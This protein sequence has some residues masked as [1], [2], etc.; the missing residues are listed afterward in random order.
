VTSLISALVAVA[1]LRGTIDVSVRTEVRARDASDGAVVG[2]LET[3]LNVLAAAKSRQWEL[4]IGYA[5]RV[6]LRG[7]IGPSPD[8]LHGVVLG[9]GYRGRRESLS[10]YGEWSV[11][12]QTWTP[13][14]PE[15][16]AGSGAAPVV[17]TLPAPL[18]IDY[19]ASRTGLLAKL[20]PARRWA[21][22]LTLEYALSGG[23][24]ARSRASLP[25]QVG[26]RGALGAEYA[27]T[28]TDHLTTTLGAQRADFSSGPEDILTQATESWRHALGR[29]TESTLGGGAAWTTA[30]T[31]ASATFRTLTLPVVE[32]AIAHR[33]PSPRIDLRASGRVAPVID[34]ITGVMDERVDASSSASWR[35]TRALSILATVGGLQSIA[36]AR[37]GAVTVLFHQLSVTYRANKVVQLEG[38]TRSYWWSTR[39]AEVP[40]P[41]WAVFAGATLTAPQVRF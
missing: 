38:G 25:F 9:A 1:A 8:V 32:A 31:S 6:T 26:P 36:W 27:L 22:S 34:P 33:I 35:A 11:G 15:A 29:N 30:R 3:A 37:P 24:D 17:G 13:L 12:R 20:V 10:L 14:V 23:T 2:D 41:Q 7:D 39:G 16:M 5:P 18:V 4:K 40:L 21:L 19:A 28:R